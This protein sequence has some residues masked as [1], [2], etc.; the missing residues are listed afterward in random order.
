MLNKLFNRDTPERED[1]LVPVAKMSELVP[2]KLKRITVKG[3]SIVLAL[4]EKANDQPGHDVVAFAGICPHALGDLSQ[5]W[6]TKGEIDC[7]IHYYR[8]DTRTGEC[9]YPKGGPALRVYPVT[10]EDGIIL[11]SVEPPKWMDSSAE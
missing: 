2:G 6:L 3:Q 7:P 9:R 10:I 4:A 5:G 11:L 1:G 8:F